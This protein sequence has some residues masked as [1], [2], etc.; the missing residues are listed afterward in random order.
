MSHVSQAPLVQMLFFPYQDG[1]GNSRSIVMWDSR[2]F[3]L[4]NLFLQSISGCWME[5][6]TSC[7]R[8]W[9]PCSTANLSGFSPWDS[10][11]PLQMALKSAFFSF[12][13][14]LLWGQ[15]KEMSQSSGV[16]LICMDSAWLWLPQGV[17]E[18]T[19]PGAMVWKWGRTRMDVPQQYPDW[20]VTTAPVT[21]CMHRCRSWKLN[22]WGGAWCGQRGISSF[23]RR[24]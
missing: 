23:E 1:L 8:G 14:L 6:Q 15:A 16:D 19:I 17:G 3:W 7:A 10:I 11:V 4:P 9:S 21:S 22:G 5:W 24:I 12:K 18:E 20:G 2:M 13:S